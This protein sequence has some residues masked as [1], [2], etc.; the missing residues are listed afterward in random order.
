MPENLD[1]NGLVS[2][3]TLPSGQI[4]AAKTAL[5]SQLCIVSGGPG[6]GKTTS[7][8]LVLATLLKNEP[9]LKIGLAAPTGKA[10]MR[11]KESI[12]NNIEALN[13]EQGIIDKLNTVEAST[14]HRLLGYQQQSIYFRH[15]RDNPLLL[16]VL[17]V[18]ES[19][20]ID[21]AMMA[22]L[23]DAVPEQA[24]LIL[25]GDKDQLPPIEAGDPFARICEWDRF[26]NK[27]IDLLEK[28]IICLEESHRFDKNSGIGKLAEA[29]KA[30]DWENSF[31]I[32]NDKSYP[33][34]V[35]QN[36]EALYSNEIKEQDNIYLR[37]KTGFN[38]YK[39]FL[40]QIINN[41]SDENLN[42]LFQK[43]NQFTL[44]NAIRKGPS[45]VEQTNKLVEKSLGFNSDN[46][47]Y[48]GKVIMVTQ[49]D[50]QTGLFNGD[51]GICLKSGDTYRIYFPQADGYQSFA[52][53]RVPP[54]ET[55]FA[56]TVHK[57]QGSEFNEVLFILPNEETPILTKPL[58]YTA[59]TRAKKTVEIWGRKEILLG[60]SA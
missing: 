46:Y 20:M 27:D 4:N 6:T 29:V 32:M 54:H 49:N 9:H 28:N 31:K 42:S 44:L 14:L 10:A 57:S 2:S 21:S 8:L 37:I 19:S 3:F 1:L 36:Y 5:K 33:D 58:V 24:R 23:L 18:D 47:W 34:L 53:M 50:Y 43:L 52:V 56:I 16:D 38:D 40:D 51:V 55:A 11:M 35:W 59:I 26:F 60:I 15:H 7:V 45:G 48:H 39:A 12:R 25:L 22:K 17:I 41:I 30:D 13:C